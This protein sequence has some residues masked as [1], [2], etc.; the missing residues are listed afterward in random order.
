MKFVNRR[1]AAIGLLLL[2]CL[3]S[4]GCCLTPQ[5]VDSIDGNVDNIQFGICDPVGDTGRALGNG[6]IALAKTALLPV[7]IAADIVVVP[8]V[9]LVWIILTAG[10][11]GSPPFGCRG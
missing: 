11:H 8:P 5:L 2:P 10:G 9:T 3:V 6:T 1:L 4:P 7:A